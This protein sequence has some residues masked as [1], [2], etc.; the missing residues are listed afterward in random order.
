MA[1][2]GE[3]LVELVDLLGDVEGI[4]E[5]ELEANL[6]ARLGKGDLVKSIFVELDIKTL[7]IVGDIA[8]CTG[9]K[10]STVFRMCL[11]RRLFRIA[12][13]PETPIEFDFNADL[14]IFAWAEVENG[15]NTVRSQF[16]ELLHRRFTLQPDATQHIIEG[17]LQRFERFAEVYQKNLHGT[18]FHEELQEDFGNRAFTD[19]EN[20]IEEVTS[21]QLEPNDSGFLEDVDVK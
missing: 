10:K 12:D 8:D 19:T 1:A 14:F 11:F 13:N 3:T 15:L 16:H 5:E 20:L 7:G 4:Q 18:S 9:R 17:D 21:I 6:E 2:G